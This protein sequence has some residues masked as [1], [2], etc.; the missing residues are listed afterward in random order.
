[1]KKSTSFFIQRFIDVCKQLK[2]RKRSERTLQQKLYMHETKIFIQ[3]HIHQNHLYVCIWKLDNF[4][5]CFLSLWFFF[6]SVN[7]IY[8]FKLI[9]ILLCQVVFKVLFMYFNTKNVQPLLSVALPTT[10]IVTYDLPK[11]AS[12]VCVD[13]R[14]RLNFLSIW[15][16]TQ[17]TKYC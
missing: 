13:N 1:M 2:V 8:I 9:F 11:I 5:P 10:Y 4:F 16:L 17:P 15:V 12:V 7:S 6:F 3:Q 14:L